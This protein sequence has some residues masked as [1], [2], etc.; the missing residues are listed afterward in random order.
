MN[1]RARPV[2][3]SL[4]LVLLAA[5][6][7]SIAAW[8]YLNASPLVAGLLAINLATFPLWAWDKFQARRGGW[9]VPEATLHLVA[10]L[11]AAGSSLAAMR[12]F[13][14]KTSKRSF[15]VLYSVLLVAQVFALL[16]FLKPP[17]AE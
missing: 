8:R 6:L 14:H 7:I 4:G 1:H 13:R 3:I 16:W 11:G 10:A 17:S 5:L 2:Q 9:R 15:T 12:L